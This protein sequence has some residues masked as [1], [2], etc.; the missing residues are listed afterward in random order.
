MSNQNLVVLQLLSTI[1]IT[2]MLGIDRF[3]QRQIGLGTIKLL[4]GGGF[5]I[6]YLID[7]V[8]HVYE[9]ISGSLTTITDANAVF[10]PCGKRNAR[11]VGYLIICVTILVLFFG[12]NSR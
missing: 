1:P 3:Y 8:L 4:T 7:G 5:G 10:D 6:W 9:G 2:G 12:L 11:I